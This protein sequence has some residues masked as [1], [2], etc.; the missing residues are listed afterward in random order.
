MTYKIFFFKNELCEFAALSMFS[1]VFLLYYAT[2]VKY[3]LV[4][5]GTGLRFNC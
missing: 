1:V 3:V 2:A 5:S 4:R